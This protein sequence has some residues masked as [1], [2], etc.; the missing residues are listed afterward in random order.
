MAH[1]VMLRGIERRPLFVDDCDRGD[2]LCRLS[3]LIPAL[4]F[5]CFAWAFMPN[6][7]HLVV[8]SGPVRLSRL[9]ARLGTG[10]ALRF[11]SRHG[12]VG[13][14][15]QNRFRS[16]IVADDADLHGLVLYVTRNPLEAGLVRDV[17][18]LERYPW[19]GLGAL[20]G[21]RVVHPFEA[22][23]EALA[24]FGT[25]PTHAREQ[26]RALLGDRE[27]RPVGSNL[28]DREARLVVPALSGRG[29]QE[30][31]HE[32]CSGLDVSPA[33]LGSRSRSPR[34][35]AAWSRVAMRAA[36]DLGLS[37]AEIA[38]AMGISRAA[39]SL[40]LRSRRDSNPAF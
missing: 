11:N 4:G 26:L 15:F 30:L 28:C 5:L 3:K 16:R 34:L 25:Q 10:Y 27:A 6:H 35:A 8:R 14:L 22:G 13:H 36:R 33:Q 12:R 17:A 29:F 24:L 38:R 37:G 18:A 23:H 21:H 40:M 20:M 39:V 9:M 7:L 19:C 31:L 32:V 2:L 1:H